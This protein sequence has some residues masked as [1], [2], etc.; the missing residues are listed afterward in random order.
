MSKLFKFILICSSLFFL[1]SGNLFGQHKKLTSLVNP[2]IG[3][4]GFGHTFPGATQPFGMVQLSPDTRTSGWENCSGYHSSNPTIIGFSHTHLSGTG[5]SDYGDI[6]FMATKGIQ[7]HSGIESEPLS[8]YRSAFNHETERASPGYYRVK[9]ED[10]GIQAEMTVTTRCG[11]QKYTF[12]ASDSSVIITDLVH[13]ISDKVTDAEITFSN[14]KIMSGYRRSKGWAKNHIIYFYAE[15]S[16]PFE[17]SGLTNAKGESVIGNSYKNAEGAKAW[18]LFR[19][20]KFEAIY[21]KVGISTVSVENAKLNLSSE[22]PAWDF[23]KTTMD[24][25]TSWDNELNRILVEGATKNDKI[26]FYTALYHTMIS[27]NIMSD[28]DGRY[29]GMDGEIHKIERGNMYTVFSLW[30]T[31]RALH[32]LFTIIDPQRAQ[33][34]VRAL[35]IKYKESGLLP[36]W[37][38]ASNETDCMIG[39]HSIP[40]I[41]DAWAKGLKDFDS[42]IA[43]EAMVK[44]S[45]QDHLGLKN[46]KSQGY[47]PADKENESVSKTLEYAYDDWCIAMMAKDLGKINEYNQ[48]LKRS[49]SYLNVYDVESGFM[50][51][52]K[53]SNWVKPFDPFEV[54]GIY[55]EANAWQY[56]WFIPHDS[57]S[58]IEMMGGSKTFKNRLDTLFSTSAK[59]TGRSQPDISGM[60]GQYAHGNEP[61]HHLAYLYNFTDEPG[62]SAIL[63]RKIMN[64]FYTNNRD[65]LIGNED[66][67]QMSAWYVFSAMG[68]YPVCPGDNSY[69]FGSPLFNKITIG[70]GNGNKFIIIADS[71]NT[72]NIF[73]KDALLNGNKMKQ[74]LLHKD[75][76]NGGILNF[77]MTNIL[78]GIQFP[79]PAS[80]DTLK[81]VMIPFLRSGEKAFLDSCSIDMQTY[82]ENATIRYTTD[83]TEPNS[84]SRMYTKPFHIKASTNFKMKGFKSGMENSFTEESSFLKL[85]Y[86]RTISYT[87]P[88]SHLYTAGGNNGLID[89]INGEPNAFGS[90]QGF[91]GDDFEVI[92]DLEKIRSFSKINT[93][94]LQQY[95]SWIWFPTQVEYAVSTDGKN[96]RQVYT[97]KNDVSTD[98]DGSFVKDFEAIIPG[99]KARFVK[100]TAKNLGVCPSWHPGAGEKA[101]IFVDEIEIE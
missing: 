44:S 17:K 63:V 13:G 68:F 58:M 15:F 2:F 90:W 97:K 94:F 40:V 21:V 9:L 23:L 79:I 43:F 86:R 39:Y 32:P 85:P 101:W 84:D 71:L 7:M 65:G 48:F 95:P 47:I 50:R 49:K 20:K 92:I 6:L 54:S 8:G 14:N 38:L 88:Y 29:R 93:T 80:I 100:V 18:V 36:V 87:N 59:L 27:P 76:M 81:V 77:K 34:F 31:F 72:Q 37:E 61:S 22:I 62:N 10:Y 33:D 42:E 28:V 73:I 57:K 46:Y 99:T 11:F 64:E 26:N 25:S 51:G 82:T 89:G 3:T 83:G 78:T 74:P 4:D 12:P 24:A 96:Y 56:T 67:G 35:L 70:N 98:A 53:N 5:A 52:K 41:Y 30:D 55:T 69:Y 16:K 75:L 66:C 91:Y 60:I 45:M 19:T 1:N